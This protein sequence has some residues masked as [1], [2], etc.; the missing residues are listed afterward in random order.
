MVMVVA[1]VAAVCVVRREPTMSQ[2]RHGVKHGADVFFW[3]FAKPF[4]VHRVQHCAVTARTK[5]NA[6][7]AKEWRL[8]NTQTQTH[9]GPSPEVMSLRRRRQR[10]SSRAALR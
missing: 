10:S 9:D 2:L 4:G 3:G 5:T 8:P 7:P 6:T 1:P